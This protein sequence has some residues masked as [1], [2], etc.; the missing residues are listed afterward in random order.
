MVYPDGLIQT[1]YNRS[2]GDIFETKLNFLKHLNR[3]EYYVC[4]LIPLDRKTGSDY[5]N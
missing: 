3:E 4:Y 1:K 5:G 2:M